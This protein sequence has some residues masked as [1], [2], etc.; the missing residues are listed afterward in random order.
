MAM[1]LGDGQKHNIGVKGLQPGRQTGASKAG[2][3]SDETPESAAP[4]DHVTQGLDSK[5]FKIL[6]DPTRF[7]NVQ[8]GIDKLWDKVEAAADDTDIPVA[9]V[10]KGEQEVRTQ[11]IIFLDT[12]DHAL[13][14]Q[15]YILRYRDLPG[16]SENDN[17]TLKYRGQDAD[18]VASVDVSAAPGIKSKP[19]FELDETFQGEQE[20]YVYSK[21]TKVKVPHLPKTTVENLSEYFPALNDLGLSSDTKLQQVNCGDIVEE[22]HLLGNIHIGKA[23]TAPAYLTL[24]YD[25]AHGDA[26]AVAEFSFAH[27]VHAS[28]P[29]VD[30][31]SA[32]LMCNLRD[33]APDWLSHGSTKTKF[34]YGE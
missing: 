23:E 28:Q 13:N 24:W 10:K 5:E 3:T 20:G 1:I 21:S 30:E 22:R 16:G 33:S 18:K 12:E 25:D 31:A 7:Q 8:K 6:L 34:A 9:K 26:P 15:G 19:K 14:N 17:L 2:P 11:D 4:T 27:Q 32:E 29:R